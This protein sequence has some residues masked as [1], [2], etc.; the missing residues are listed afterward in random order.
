MQEAQ[1]H[2]FQ[3][4]KKWQRQLTAWTVPNISYNVR[5]SIFSLLAQNIWQTLSEAGIMKD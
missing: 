3:Q 4:L 2:S 1:N 5:A